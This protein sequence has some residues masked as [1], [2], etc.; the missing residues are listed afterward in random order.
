MLVSHLIAGAF[1]TEGTAPTYAVHH[2]GTGEHCHDVQ[3]SSLEDIRAAVS[4]CHQAQPAWSARPLTSRCDIFMRVADFL[5]DPDSTWKS[6]LRDA[7]RAETDI[8]EWWSQEQVDF[9][10]ADLRVLVEFAGAALQE[11]RVEHAGCESPAKRSV[12]HFSKHYYHPRAVWRLCGDPL[13]ECCRLQWNESLAHSKVHPLTMRAIVT[14]LLAGNTVVLKTSETT[15][16]TQTLWAQL[17]YDAGVPCEALSVVHI[18]AGDAPSL[19]DALVSDKRVRHVNFTGSTRVGAIIAALAGRHLKPT[20]MELGGKAPILLLPDADLDT[21][22]SHI[23]F[24]AFMGSGQLCMSTER[25]LVFSSMYDRL[26]DALR[27]AWE[28]VRKGQT[29]TLFSSASVSRVEDL[30]Q[31]AISR[32]ASHLLESR[33]ANDSSSPRQLN[34]KSSRLTPTILGPITPHMKL[35]SEETFGPVAAVIVCDDEGVTEESAIDGMIQTANDSDYGLT[36]AVWGRD[37]SRA[38]SI[39]RRLE[40]GAVHINKAANCDPPN[41]PHGGWKSSGWGRFNG[42]EGIRSFTQTRSVDVP[43]SA[44]EP[45]PLDVFGL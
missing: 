4:C 11:E 19:I 31:D 30:V 35:Y 12:D 37:Q 41:V 8:S 27:K 34:G 28:T 1:N 16:L 18:A 14:P 23:L 40:C 13:L 44:S 3:A 9:I 20:L 25:I 7:N 6:K 38:A 36:S 2:P 43:V 15:P 17:L 26:V 29:K 24:G 10:S 21:A 5:D 32:G 42:V 22:A 45:L 39:A 33:D